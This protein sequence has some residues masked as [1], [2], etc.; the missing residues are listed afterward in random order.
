VPVRLTGSLSD[1]QAE[2]Q[3]TSMLLRLG[4]LVAKLNPATA[5]PAFGLAALE[6]LARGNPCVQKIRKA[7]KDSR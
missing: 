1:P 6:D 5:L 4:M 7:A 2:I 3:K